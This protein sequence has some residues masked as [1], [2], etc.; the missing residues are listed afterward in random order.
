MIIGSDGLWELVN[1]AEMCKIIKESRNKD[2]ISR[3]I[4][5]FGL[6]KASINAGLTVDKLNTL[7]PG[8]ERRKIHD[9]I[10]IMVVDLKN[11]VYNI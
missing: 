4:L 5:E 6:K 3:R 2:L 10:T 7:T 1:R 11:Q 8:P 9:D